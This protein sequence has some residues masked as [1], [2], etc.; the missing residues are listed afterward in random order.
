MKSTTTSSS[1]NKKRGPDKK[2]DIPTLTLEVVPPKPSP[3]PPHKKLKPNNHPTIAS[4]NR[5]YLT[6]VIP[7]ACLEQ[8]IAIA[9]LEGY[10]GKAG[11]VKAIADFLH[12]DPQTVLDMFCLMAILP[13]RDP[14]RLSQDV[15]MPQEPGSQYPQRILIFVKDEEVSAKDFLTKFAHDLTQWANESSNTA[16]TGSNNLFRL[17]PSD[18]TQKPV[19]YYLR[20]KDTLLLL[21]KVYGTVEGITKSDIEHDHTVLENFFGTAKLGQ[22]ILGTL[23]EVQWA[24]LNL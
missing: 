6:G 8:G 20:T 14:T 16:Y 13:R 2:E 9:Y 17:F 10:R 15:M 23:S 7:L 5:Q 18:D 3:R 4:G 1:A 19:N 12:T 22:E 24:N 21:K 11:Y